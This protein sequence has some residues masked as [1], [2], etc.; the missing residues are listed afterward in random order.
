M[1]FKKKKI[2]I[3]F[4]KKIKYIILKIIFI[5][6]IISIVSILSIV[7]YYYTSGMHERF[8]PYAL[9]K[10]IDKIIL[11]RYLGFSIFEIDDYIKIK[12]QSFKYIFIKNEFENITIKIDQK[13]LYNLELQRKNK[14][15]GSSRDFENFSTAKLENDKGTFNIKLRV[16]GDRVLHWYDKNQTSYKIDLRGED[17]IWGL[18]EFSVQKPITRNY[19][20]ESIFHKLLKFNGLISLKYFFINLSL[21]DT[22]QGIYAVEEGFSKELIERSKRRN[23]PI[24]G[25]NE[26]EGTDYPDIEYDLYSEKF[27][28]SN[29]PELTK[30][31]LSKLNDL[32][33]GKIGVNEIFDLEKWS[34]FFA[35]IDLSNTLHG[36]LS[37]SVKL[38]Y[39]PVNAKFEPVGFDGHYNPNLF[40]DFLILD[41]LDPK[42]TNCSYICSDKNWYL[43]FLKNSDGSIN[44][45]FLDLY[46]KALQKI[47]TQAFLDAFND[48]YY[49][50]IKFNND[51]L[52]SEVS[53]KDRNYY[54]GLGFYIFDENFLYKKSR[55]IKNRLDKIEGKKKLKKNLDA[56]KVKM[57]NLLENNNIEF[58]DEEYHLT[59]DLILQN[60]YFLSKGNKLNIKEGIKIFFKKDVS[61]ISEGSI[62]F[63]GTKEKPIIIF[64]DE[65]NGSF[66]LS[67]NN[68]NF[69]NVL[70]NNLSFPKNKNMILHGGINLI[71]SNVSIIDTEINNSHSEDAINII[72]SKT[73]IK[74]LKMSNIS[75]DAI[76]IDFG[77]LK[78]ENILCKNILNDCLD[79]SGGE[80]QGQYF[81]AIDVMDKGL[82]F[83][84]NSIG[85]ISNSSFSKNKLAI[86]VKDGSQLLLSKYSFKENNFDIAVFNKKKE[87]GSS[88]LNLEDL[89]AE[90]DL[91]ILL[92]KNNNILAK[93]DKEIKKVKNNY[94]NQLF[95]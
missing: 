94:I 7:G 95:Y 84:E 52:T 90:N 54:K 85:K 78:F 36:S 72:S 81:Q 65:G 63:N 21:N 77:E 68:Y 2:E 60:D 27:W 29:H 48:K 82:S 34:K 69:K 17:R 30:I 1:I 58:L 53:K 59:K 92:G 14:T 79:V 31:A 71:N 32:K 91:S 51:Q 20:Y 88:T 28:T 5:T 42:N 41:F 45:K 46:T 3:P 40:N 19:V 39:N 26:S 43:S 47:S 49:G 67:N 50:E 35:L 75:A 4:F 89:K 37:K 24:F 13:N 38:Y 10:K 16:K 18:E 55:Y 8:K 74:N 23:G 61:I 9:I 22:N 6:G 80:V 73:Y 64:S 25:L 15:E 57:L 76:D 44:D 56:T 33:Q 12:F 93:T 11:D 87:Y 70:F 83:G 62:F 86:A 66:I